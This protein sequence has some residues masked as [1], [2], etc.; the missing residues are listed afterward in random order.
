M[1]KTTEKKTVI[2]LE[3]SGRRADI[4]I[5][6]RKVQTDR[7]TVQL[8]P[9]SEYTELSISSRLWQGVR[10]VGGGQC[11]EMVREWFG[12]RVP[13]NEFA[14]QNEPE[15]GWGNSAALTSEYAVYQQ[16][17]EALLKILEIWERWH[18]NAMCAGTDRQREALK[19]C[20]SKLYDKQCKHLEGRGLLVDDRRELPPDTRG[21]AWSAGY[22]IGVDRRPV[23]YKYGTAW[24]VEE[25]PQEVLRELDIACRAFGVQLSSEFAEPL[26]PLAELCLEHSI[27]I[28][29]TFLGAEKE[30]GGGNWELRHFIVTLQ[31][32]NFTALQDIDF[33][34]GMAFTEPPTV[35]DVLSCLVAAVEA[36]EM[37]FEEY[38]STYGQST[39]SKAHEA[40]KACAARAPQVRAF[41]GDDFD[42]FVGAEN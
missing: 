6:L 28:V 40:W 3:S 11:L 19:D 15:S 8:K 34:Q 24:L 35:A 31:R 16:R 42:Q 12:Q 27:T 25:L 17:H 30:P 13:R 21:D 41:L 38:C 9:I 39:D 10:D 5:E 22:N 14:K 1:Q 2:R 18:L 29:P 37:D 33:R 20:A 36:G 26:T 7:R 32:P 23:G 4:T